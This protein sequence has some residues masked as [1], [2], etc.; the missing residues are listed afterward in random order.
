MNVQGTTRMIYN[1]SLAMI[2]YL[3]RL[4]RFIDIDIIAIYDIIVIAVIPGG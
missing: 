4:S 3:L 2:A 1:K